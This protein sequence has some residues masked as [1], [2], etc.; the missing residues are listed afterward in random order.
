MVNLRKKPRVSL[1]KRAALQLDDEK[2]V[3]SRGSFKCAHPYEMVFVFAADALCVIYTLYWLFATR[4][5]KPF[6][7]PDLLE[8]KWTLFT[9]FFVVGFIVR[10]IIV[11]IATIG[12]ECE[13]RAEQTEF[14]I[15]GP[16]RR[17]EIFYY[18]DVQEVRHEPLTLYGVKRGYLIT[19]VTGVREV[20]YRYIYSDRKLMTDFED[21][22]FYFLAVNSGLMEYRDEPSGITMEQVA[23]MMVQRGVQ[24]LEDEKRQQRHRGFDD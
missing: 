12:R 22:P 14:T 13:Y 3:R 1:E 8:A 19:V 18:N 5:Y 24:R 7:D 20:Q 11:A 15:E 23:G 17:R 4:L 10:S 6:E 9:L 2:K 21:T 16:A